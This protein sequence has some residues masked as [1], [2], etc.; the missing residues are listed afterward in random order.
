MNSEGKELFS[1]STPQSLHSRKY[2]NMGATINIDSL[3]SHSS[4]A[5]LSRGCFSLSV[6]VSDG[7]QVWIPSH[8]QKKKKKKF[9]VLA[10]TLRVKN[11]EALPSPSSAAYARPGHNPYPVF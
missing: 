3:I 10:L 4:R 8:I 6:A 11:S 1:L 7:G 9:Q 2:I 5:H